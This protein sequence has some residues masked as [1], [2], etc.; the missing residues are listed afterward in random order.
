MKTGGQIK[1]FN[2][3]KLIKP[4]S[5]GNLTL[6]SDID[7]SRQLHRQSKGNISNKRHRTTDLRVRNLVFKGKIPT[8]DFY[9]EIACQDMRRTFS[10]WAPQ[11]GRQVEDSL[12]NG[13]PYYEVF[14]RKRRSNVLSRMKAR[15]KAHLSAV[16]NKIS[17]DLLNNEEKNF[18]LLKVFDGFFEGKFFNNNKQF[19]G[20]RGERLDKMKEY[21]RQRDRI[22]V[23]KE[24]FLNSKK[25][26]KRG[27]DLNRLDQ[28]KG[29]GSRPPTS[30]YQKDKKQGGGL[31]VPKK[32][33]IRQFRTIGEKRNQGAKTVK[34]R[35]KRKPNDPLNSPDFNMVGEDRAGI[36]R[37]INSQIQTRWVKNY[38]RI[39][40]NHQ[41]VKQLNSKQGEKFKIK[42]ITSDWKTRKTSYKRQFF[43]PPKTTEI[44]SPTKSKQMTLALYLQSMKK[45]QYEILD[46]C[47]SVI[48]KTLKIMLNCSV[49]LEEELIERSMLSAIS[50]AQKKLVETFSETC[51]ISASIL[52][53]YNKRVYCCNVG[54][55]RT[56]FISKTNYKQYLKNEYLVHFHTNENI[57][58]RYRVYNK[59]KKEKT[60]GSFAEK[61]WQK[62]EKNGLRQ[63]FRLTRALGVHNLPGVIAEPEVV[64]YDVKE[65]EIATG[66][67]LGS[68]DLFEILRPQLVM[69]LI[70]DG[71]SLQDLD[72]AMV[73]IC[74]TFKSRVK[75]LKRKFRISQAAEK[76]KGGRSDENIYKKGEIE[77]DGAGGFV[78]KSNRRRAEEEALEKDGDG[79]VR[80]SP[81]FDD[82]AC[83]LIYF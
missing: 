60:L 27:E 23:V 75:N 71:F 31:G 58:E 14:H 74:R 20:H 18:K 35:M 45:G 7:I 13:I 65:N 59:K 2:P 76:G 26:R 48:M 62:N 46:L 32:K 56:M 3:K 55:T 6:M 52:I 70:E 47:K 78:L 17:M 41:D 37:L 49:I 11:I 44:F 80:N 1:R 64:C 29:M 54:G 24:N 5:A 10:K 82:F 68:L 61:D 22:I 63:T 25:N 42:A 19:S 15:N 38:R 57:T 73:D 34:K 28:M 30:T 43:H 12:T 33:K 40:K 53:L 81:L 4:S 51:L 69:N 67:L 79:T 9:E 39:L 77:S 50:K 36:V 8:K 21:F 66:V 72:R 83:V 16:H